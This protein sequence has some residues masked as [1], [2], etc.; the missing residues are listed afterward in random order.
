MKKLFSYLQSEIMKKNGGE[1]TSHFFSHR[2]N[3]YPI[4]MK[5]I[6]ALS[7]SLMF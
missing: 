6:Q 5:G 1:T 7:Q 4:L 3:Y 2:L